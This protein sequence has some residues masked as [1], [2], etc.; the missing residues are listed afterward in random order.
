MIDTETFANNNLDKVRDPNLNNG[1]KETETMAPFHDITNDKDRKQTKELQLYMRRNRKQEKETND[2]N[3]NQISTLQ[4]LTDIQG[5]S[6]E[7][8]SDLSL[9][10]LDLVFQLPN[11]KRVTKSR[12]P[13]HVKF[14][15]I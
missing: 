14:C 6:S 7:P 5:N 9:V 8:N 12:K 15:V 4:D 13:S 10:T 11:I 2:S 3:Q 1:N